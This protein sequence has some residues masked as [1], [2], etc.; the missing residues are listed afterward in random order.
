MK[1]QLTLDALAMAYGAEN[2]QLDY[3]IIFEKW[4]KFVSVFT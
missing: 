2:R 3:F 1:K 4:L